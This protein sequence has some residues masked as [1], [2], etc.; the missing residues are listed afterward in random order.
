M[1]NLI[2]LSSDLYLEL[3]NSI[4]DAHY[5][6]KPELKTAYGPEGRQKCVDDAVIHLTYLHQA[7]ENQSDQLFIDYVLWAKT[8]FEGINLP[9]AHLQ[10]HLDIMGDVLRQRLN[11]QQ[12]GDIGR[13]ILA[14]SE[15]LSDTTKAA[16][17]FLSPDCPHA[18]LAREYLDLLI[19]SNRTGASQLILKA[20]K[21]D[22][23]PVQEIYLNVFQPCQREVGLL[24]QTGRMSVAQEHF[25]TAAT[26]LCMSQLYPFIFSSEK[27]G[28]VSVITCAQD[29]LHEVGVRMV[30]DLLE[31][32]GWDAFYLG[33]NV[34]VDSVIEFVAD[35]QPDMIGISATITS[36]LPQV[37]SL[38]AQIRQVQTKPTCIMVGGYPFNISP[39]L[40]KELGADAQSSDAHTAIETANKLAASDV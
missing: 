21:D 17:S 16:D 15:K 29:E 26:Q 9:I 37:K 8:L 40:Y 12:A 32:N 27:N 6:K 10:D 5:K 4:T 39:E 11:Q 18:A 35:K 7:L 25:C 1:S 30:A 38:I 2:D 22:Q 19:A 28:K 3:A 14:A 36:H 33:A 13:I 20:V 31:M 24:W 23:I 34:P